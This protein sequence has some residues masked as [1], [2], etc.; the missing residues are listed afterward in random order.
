MVYGGTF[1]ISALSFFTT[2]NGLA[3]IVSYPLAII[4]SLGFQG[5][6][7]GIA[8]SLIR[9][10]RNR[11]TYVVV[12]ATAA[13]F[14]I[15]FSYA[16]FDSKLREN[17]RSMD[18][19]NAFAKVGREVIEER[20]SLAKR[21]RLTGQ[22]QLDRLSHLIELE[23]E[24]G[25]A[26]LVDE[27]SQDLF[28]QSVIEGAR[29]TVKA[30]SANEGR[31]YHQG[32]GRGII[33]N[34]LESRRGQSRMLL[35][36]VNDYVQWA[37]TI[38]TRVSERDSVA[39]QFAYVNR[40]V[41]DFPTSEIEMI[42]GRELPELKALPQP[43]E[44]AE[45]A[46][47]SQHA[48]ALVIEDLFSMNPLAIF[49]LALAF[50]IDAIILLVALA[51]SRAISD[52]DSSDFALERVEEEA[53]SRLKSVSL[54]NPTILSERLEENLASYRIAARYR[55]RLSIL[56][57]ESRA[58]EQG[59]RI[60]IPNSR[61]AILESDLDSSG[62]NNPGSTQKDRSSTKIIIKSS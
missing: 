25:W 50:A 17:T 21:A 9:I 46:T 62:E 55:D 16:N 32:S 43:G 57:D 59:K 6:M 24:H 10:K 27:G 60:V 49:S 47:S 8:W 2:L 4:G 13:I 30:W 34:Y 31:D 44:F 33:I 20:S 1:L 58:L 45:K 12:F 3:I 29:R 28:V 5:A 22:Y 53:I 42:L 35:N 48:L 38:A 7:L 15:F 56:K 26:T 52:V 39:V 61:V 14:S 54:D 37:D 36:R 23:E 11:M 40:V 18:A 41:I 19:R 51:G